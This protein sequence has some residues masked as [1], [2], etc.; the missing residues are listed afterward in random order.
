VHDPAGGIWEGYE[1]YSGQQ[2]LKTEDSC[3]V[4]Q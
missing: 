2:E 1:E 4:L 3:D